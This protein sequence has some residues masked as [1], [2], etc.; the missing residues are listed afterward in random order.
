[1]SERVLIGHGQRKGRLL[2]NEPAFRKALADGKEVFTG[3]KVGVWFSV[4]L[5]DADEIVYTALPKRPRDL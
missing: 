3:P 5:N 1:M 4:A 2:T